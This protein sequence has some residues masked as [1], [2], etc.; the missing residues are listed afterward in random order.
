MYIS[1]VSIGPSIN[2]VTSSL[3]AS[4]AKRREEGAHVYGPP[5]YP[6][7]SNSDQQLTSPYNITTS[8][9]LHVMRINKMITTD[10]RSSCLNKFSQIAS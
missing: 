8:S 2:G 9:N 10:K 1:D 6:S 3:P 7:S 5:L 4:A